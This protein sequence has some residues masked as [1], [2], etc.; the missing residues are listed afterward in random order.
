MSSKLVL[1]CIAGL[2]LIAVSTLS[3]AAEIN[4]LSPS[5]Q[6]FNV[7]VTAPVT[8]DA[9]RYIDIHNPLTPI[10]SRSGGSATWVATTL[11]TDQFYRDL[12]N[13]LHPSFKRI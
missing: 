6:K 10:F 2:S 11:R 13:P 4:P 1:S 3:N 7:A 5:Y 9:T 8:G 12:A